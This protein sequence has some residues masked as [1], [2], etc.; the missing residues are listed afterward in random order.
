MEAKKITFDQDIY[1]SELKDLGKKRQL[2]PRVNEL[3]RK[4]LKQEQYESYLVYAQQITEADNLEESEE[5]NM[6]LEANLFN[7]EDD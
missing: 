2:S 3:I 1:E 6:I 7:S 5:N 4:G